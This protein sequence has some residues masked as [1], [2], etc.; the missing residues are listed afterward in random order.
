MKIEQIEGDLLDFPNGINVIAQCCNCKAVQSA[1]I[2][3]QI[4]ERYP[5]A[6]EAD[7]THHAVYQNKGNSMLGSYSS[8]RVWK[9][10]EK[11]RFVVNLYG[12]E[13]YGVEDR[14]LNY[15]AIYCAMNRLRIN[16]NIAHRNLQETV[17]GFPYGMGCGLAGGDWRIVYAMIEALFG[18]SEMIKVYIVKYLE[19]K[20]G[21]KT[22]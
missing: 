20:K 17:V 8:A 7:K 3:K 16:L 18:D 1:G 14:Q 15:E 12:Q 10:G 9:A 6:Y 2:A 11:V 21:Q 5:E 13:N 22:C 4:K 19:P